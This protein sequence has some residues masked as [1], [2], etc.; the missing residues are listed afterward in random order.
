MQNKMEKKIKV[1]GM[2]CKSCEVLI[3]DSLSDIGVKSKVNHKT[4]EVL[5]DFDPKKV[6]IEDIYKSIK[7]NGYEVLK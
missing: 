1:K 5:I 3:Q 4:G 6:K 7:E 2:H